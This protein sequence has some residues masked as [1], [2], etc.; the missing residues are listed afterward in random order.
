M[1][2]LRSLLPLPLS[3]RDA[4]G[5][6]PPGA[7]VALTGAGGGI[8]EPEALLAA[9]E[10]RFLETGCPTDLTVVHA[11]GMGDRAR[12][13]TGHLAHRG[14]TKRVVGGLWT[15]SPDLLRLA[16]DE[17]IEAYAL[18]GGVISQLFREIGSRR[19]GLFTRVGLGTFADPRH[20][21]GKYNRSAV[22]DLVEHIELDGRDY[23]RYLPF[24]VDVALV[25]GDTVDRNGN[26][27]WGR[28]AAQLDAL[29]AAQAARACGGLV[30]AQVKDAI[31]G[32]L[33]P[34]LVHLPAALVDV[35]VV[36]PGQRQTHAAEFDA[37]LCS[38][39]PQTGVPE[40]GAPALPRARAIIAQRAAAEI[41]REQIINVGFGIPTHVVDVLAASGR[42]EDNSIVIEQGIVGGR[43]LSG[44]LFGAARHPEAMHAST[45]QFDLINGGLIDVTCLGMAQ[46]DATGSV[47]VSRIGGVVNGPG[48]FVEISQSAREVVFCGTFTTGGLDVDDD[49]GTLRIRRE[50]RI[51]KFVSSVDEVTFSG[52]RAAHDRQRV[53][54]ITERAV[55]TLTAAGLELTEIAPGIDL[56]RDLLAHMG[57]V[58]IIRAPRPMR[59]PH[60]HPSISGVNS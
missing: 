41:R 35:V 56:E 12:G 18:P 2:V 8:L 17:E 48:G 33:D 15:W 32:V 13:G 3:A 37:R 23:L 31:S 46:V 25:R 26:I 60:P 10:E 42:L 27:G 38:P 43:P 53:V 57:F 40:T 11:L 36:T 54:Y 49:D 59:L 28:E 14:L 44:D 45:T 52:P 4:V 6:I 47:N 30:I 1:R 19:P 39:A 5:L 7:T 55:F 20:G 50:G 34:H 16:D 24:S 22:D 21:G 58:P 9:L 51:P 29:A